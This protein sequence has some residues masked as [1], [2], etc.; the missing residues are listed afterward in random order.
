MIKVNQNVD[1]LGGVSRF[2]AIAPSSFRR[3][4]K[5]YPSGKN[6]LEIIPDN[7]VI[8][9]PDSFFTHNVN[10]ERE[11]TDGGYVYKVT[12]T[13]GLAGSAE[14]EKISDL[15]QRGEWYL[16]S[17]DS[18]G[19]GRFFGGKEEVLFFSSTLDTGTAASDRSKI[20]FQFSGEFSKSAIILDC[21]T[22][23]FF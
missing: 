3:I 23:D 20:S 21:F 4:R 11:V 22:S 13:G 17:V 18:L 2:V 15:L 12:C 5:D 6:Y 7:N 19:N 16:L 1:N 9:I 8:E 10:E 14:N